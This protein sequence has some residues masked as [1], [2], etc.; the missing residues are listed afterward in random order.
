MQLEFFP[1]L[2]GEKQFWTEFIPA[3]ER[4]V[5]T[6]LYENFEKEFPSERGIGGIGST[7]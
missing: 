4:K 2:R 6:S 7:G 3:L 1:Y 5:D